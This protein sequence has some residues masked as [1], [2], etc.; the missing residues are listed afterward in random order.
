M[1]AILLIVAAVLGSL[2]MYYSWNSSMEETS[3][4]ALK[5]ATT[6]GFSLNGEMLKQLNARPEDLGTT[7][8]ESIKKRL[9]DIV[10]IN[11]EIRF[12]YFYTQKDG[13]I[14]FMVDSEP[15]D[16]EDCSPPG[17]EFT[18]ADKEDFRPYEDG[19]ALI[20]KPVTDRW[21]TWVSALIPVKD[22]QTGKTIAVFGMDYPAKLWSNNALANTIEAG[23][24]VIAIF[25]LMLAFYKL[26][27][28]NKALNEEKKKLNHAKDEVVNA[29][30][31]IKK[32]EEKHRSLIE[33]SH[34][35]IYTFNADGVFTFVSP[36]WTTLLGQPV[37]QIEGRPF[38]QFVHPD[39]LASCIE[40]LQ[41]VIE[42]EQRQE[43][44]EYRM[45]HIDGSWYW[46]TSSVVPL[47]DDA[48]MLIGF[49][50]TARDITE[51]K[52]VQQELIKAKEQAEAATGAKSEFLANMSHEIR[53]PM[54][55]IIGFSRLIKNTNMTPKQEDYIYKID[56]SAKS[57]LGIINDIL[58]FSKIEAGKLEMEK[59]DF[60]LDDVI[61]NMLG[62]ISVETAKKNIELLSNIKDEVPLAL[63]GDPLRLGQVLI[64]LANNA[65]KFT[66]KGHI[67][68][69]T[70]LI[71]KDA[72]N[73]RIKFSVNDTGIGMTKEQIGKLFIAFSQADS[74]VT[75]RFGGT[76]LGLTISKRLVEMMGGEIFAESQFGVGSTFTFIAE[77]KRQTA[78]KAHR[79][80]DAQKL[81]DLKVLIVDDNEMARDIMKKQLDAFGI[82]ASSAD[83]GPAAILKIKKE[84]IKKPFDLVFMDWRMNG[85][86]GLEAAKII[87]GDKDIGHLPAIVMV[88]AF[89]REEIVKKAEKI[90]INAF[91]MKPVNQSLLFDTIMNLFGFNTAESLT[92]SAGNKEAADKVDGINGAKVLLVED[93]ALNQ[94][95]ATEILKS[96]GAIVNIASNG[97]QAVDAV[98]SSY[99]DIVLMDLQMPVMGGYEATSLIRINQKYKNLPIIAMTA[100][101]MQG[102]KE[103]CLAAGMNDYVSKPIEPD[104]L[105]SV[106][107]KWIKPA[108]AGGNTQQIKNTSEIVNMTNEIADENNTDIELPESIPGIDIESGVKRLSGN[109]K[110]YRKLLIDFSASYSSLPQDIGKAIKESSADTALR[111]AHTLKGVA[112][113]ISAYDIQNI[114]S[115][116]E[117][118]ISQNAKEEYEGLLSRLGEAFKS[119][120]EL[121]KGLKETTKAADSNTDEKPPLTEV[122]PVLRKLAMLIWEDNVDAGNGLEELKKCIGGSRFSEEIQALTESIGNFD[123]E[124]AKDPLQKI[125][126]KMNIR[127]RGK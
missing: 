39:D 28:I 85:M 32:S 61:N 42:T 97:M 117:N 18:E 57:L 101:A 54:N 115:N 26:L 15:A 84:S 110:L 80:I 83:S 109:R 124:A 104:Q 72:A 48:G 127:M 24:V 103:E 16:S 64:N 120:N 20:T 79:V 10:S 77:F 92:R 33:N 125:A 118:A 76:G 74:T 49:E 51:R 6:A 114:A 86:D 43:G 122:E 71:K 65:V 69:K 70:E 4:Q 29:A 88:T 21:G 111:L 1:F 105:F 40:W 23:I 95:V 108:I 19:K 113:N 56:S 81:H 37:N 3:K 102:A 38:R 44:V 94:E 11:S 62:I 126:C 55:A 8:Y 22:P 106:I 63:T 75:R 112:G 100:H 98:S 47:R 119:F 66:E 58:D 90:G 12:A 50:G 46:Y 96:A 73:C 68:I 31:E 7:A 123:F 93:N 34:D 2:Y 5:I 60:R 121:I 116:L 41:K 45:Q 67:L 87:I 30:A 59:V 91:L 14:Y 99:Y 36:A 27:S 89:G 107:K 52:H 82:N 17:Q 78:E 53:T 13:K 35:I 25:L 9:M